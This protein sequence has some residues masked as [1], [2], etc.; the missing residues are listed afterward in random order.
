M[1]FLGNPLQ[2]QTQA[3]AYRP[4]E[5]TKYNE[6]AAITIL[7]NILAAFENILC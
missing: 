7:M 2:N 6:N 1:V 3:K 5:T 4:I